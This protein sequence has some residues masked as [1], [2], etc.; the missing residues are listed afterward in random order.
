M[1]QSALS[2]GPFF[3]AVV[4][5]TS[6]SSGLQAPEGVDPQFGANP[7][8]TVTPKPS[9]GG[10]SPLKTLQD[11][12]HDFIA[13]GSDPVD[14]VAAPYRAPASPYEVKAGDIISAAL[15][16]AI[17]SDLPGEIVAQVTRNVFDH[18]TGRRLLIPQG[19][20]LLGHYDSQVAYGQSRVLIVW[21]RIIMP[22]GRS[23]NI[24]SMTGGDGQGASGLADRVDAHIGP[25][26]RAI[27]LSTAI[28]AGG[29]VAQDAATR[30]QSGLVLTD[31]AGGVS[32]QASQAGQRF[33]ERDL[34]RQPTITVRAGRS[35][36]S[37]AGT[38][39]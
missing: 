31:S 22:D 25:L 10:T 15:L 6:R 21:N 4:P 20:R 26:A 1:A 14:Y 39:C 2:A 17:N 3:G 38:S 23:I 5:S 27:A 9:D 28:T 7:W 19:A 11:L 35:S 16:T 24:G 13:N 18:S 36:S 32:A 33:I 8:A 30:S 29:L 12:K 34:G 37:P